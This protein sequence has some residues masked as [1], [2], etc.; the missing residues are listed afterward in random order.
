MNLQLAKNIKLV[1]FDVD[2][3]MTNG[4]IYMTGEGEIV[5][6]FNVKDG[7]AVEFLRSHGFYTGVISGK[8]SPALTKRC[9][10]LGFDVIITGC[11]NKLPQLASL[12]EKFHIGL[13]EIAF[14]GDDILDVPVFEHVGLSV[15]PKDAHRL[16]L[17]EADWVIPINGGEGMVREFADLL[18]VNKFELSLKEAYQPLLINIKRDFLKGVEQ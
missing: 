8:A 12:C 4:T 16:A 2:G 9:E 3:V 10:Q 1:L 13:H 14:C 7:L 11:K 18:V 15:A 5:K 17:D 6:S